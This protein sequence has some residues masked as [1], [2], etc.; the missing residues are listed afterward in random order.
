MFKVSAE[1]KGLLLWCIWEATSAQ[2]ELFRKFKL[3]SA[4]YGMM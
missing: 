4:L 3:T 1:Y 2:E